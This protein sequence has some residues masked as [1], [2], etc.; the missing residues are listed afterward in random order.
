MTTIPKEDLGALLRNKEQEHEDW[1]KRV[2]EREKQEALA[3]ARKEMKA[4]EEYL[5]GLRNAIP[6][7]AKTGY[8]WN[9]ERKGMVYIIPET[10]YYPRN[11]AFGGYDPG[12]KVD[13]SVRYDDRNHRHYYLHDQALWNSFVEWAKGYG[14]AATLQEE[15]HSESKGEEGWHEHDYYYILLK[16]LAE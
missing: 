10:R 12:H 14:L 1:L 2:A 11:H 16:P 6:I 15:G 7:D 8:K 5:E 13:F 9:S 3:K 4:A